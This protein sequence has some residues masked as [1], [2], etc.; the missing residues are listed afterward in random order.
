MTRGRVADPRPADAPSRRTTNTSKPPCENLAERSTDADI[1]TF[2]TSDNSG[3]RGIPEPPFRSLD[4]AQ[5]STWR[6]GRSRKKALKGPPLQPPLTHHHGIHHALY[7]SSTDPETSK[8]LVIT[9]LINR[10]PL[11]TG[12]LSKNTTTT[13]WTLA[14]RFLP[15]CQFGWSVLWPPPSV[16]HRIT[17]SLSLVRAR[18]LGSHTRRTRTRPDQLQF[19]TYECGRRS[20]A[21][22]SYQCPVPSSTDIFLE[23]RT[24]RWLS[25]PMTISDLE[26][27]DR[28]TNNGYAFFRDVQ[29]GPVPLFL[30]YDL[31]VHSPHYSTIPSFTELTRIITRQFQNYLL[32]I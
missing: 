6:Y 3:A 13:S 26:T 30:E 9:Y 20:L 8:L 1:L 5:V 23:S 2:L 32:T 11:F 25:V 17:H 31:S 4:L 10:S 16:P 21:L 27:N 24:I 29:N 14:L 18:A 28:S 12:I 19:H 15:A 7:L 22:I